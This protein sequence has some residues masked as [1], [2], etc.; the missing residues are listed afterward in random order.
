[1]R[2][3]RELDQGFTIT[4]RVTDDEEYLEE[5]AVE[6]NFKRKM[7]SLNRQLDAL[8][9]KQFEVDIQMEKELY[10]SD[11]REARVQELERD[12]NTRKQLCNEIKEELRRMGKEKSQILLSASELNLTE[13]VRSLDSKNFRTT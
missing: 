9:L 5:R 13:V 4:Q 10:N 7:D 11:V 6:A 1:M 2:D 12:I 3:A 8:H